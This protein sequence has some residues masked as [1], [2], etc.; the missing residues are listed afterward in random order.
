MHLNIGKPQ[1]TVRVLNMSRTGQRS[2]RT[3]NSYHMGVAET[4]KAG[5]LGCRSHRKKQRSKDMRAVDFRYREHKRKDQL[6]CSWGFCS[7]SGCQGQSLPGLA[8]LD[9]ALGTVKWKKRVS[10]DLQVSSSTSCLKLW[11]SAYG[12]W[13]RMPSIWF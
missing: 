6:A 11:L 4:L 12:G 1:R 13:E 10:Q 8:L 7:V 9:F 5:V 2:Q 3:R